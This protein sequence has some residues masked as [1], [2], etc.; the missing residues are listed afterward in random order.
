MKNILEYM[1]SYFGRKLTEQN[2]CLRTFLYWLKLSCLS[3]NLNTQ[4]THQW[5][6]RNDVKNINHYLKFF[7]FLYLNF[8]TG[9]VL[10]YRLLLW[11]LERQDPKTFFLVNQRKYEKSRKLSEV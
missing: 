11:D 1:W 8:T 6:I 9:Y 10:H 2:S 3:Y 7:L 4:L 5:Y